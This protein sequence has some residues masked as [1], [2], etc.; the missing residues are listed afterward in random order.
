[1]S[2]ILSNLKVIEIASVLA[3][4]A[5]GMFLAERG[6]KVIKIENKKTG[7]DVTRTWKL[8][9]EDSNSP[10]SAYF[11]SV[12]WNKEYVSIDL[13]DPDERSRLESYIKEADILIANFKYG[14]AKKFK[15]DFNALKNIY[16]RII[17]AE[18]SGFCP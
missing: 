8:A 16:P 3:G 9:S 10:L 11:C 4:P 14:D 7:G 2:R 5:V 1:V 17:H 12:N 6:A 18:L 15:L 13:S